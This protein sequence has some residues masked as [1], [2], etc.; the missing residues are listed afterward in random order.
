MAGSYCQR[1][2]RARPRTRPSIPSSTQLEA[3]VE[4]VGVEREPDQARERLPLGVRRE[5]ARRFG[6]ASASSP[7]IRDGGLG[8][9]RLDDLLGVGA[10]DRVDRVEALDVAEDVVVD[11]HDELEAL[12]RRQPGLGHHRERLLEVERAVRAV[13]DVLRHLDDPRVAHEDRAG[14]VRDLAH[15]GAPA[16]GQLVG[17][18]QQ[19]AHDRVL[20][21]REQLV[22]RADVVVERHRPGLRARRRRG[23]SRAPRSP[24][25][26]RCGSRRA[27]SRRACGRAVGR[28]ARAGSRCSRGRRQRGRAAGC[29]VCA[30]GHWTRRTVYC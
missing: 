19:L 15:P 6:N 24:R 1:R 10:R 14:A 29:G 7:A 25:R 11:E 2:G 3:A 13:V 18:D 17:R 20:D 30:P 12:V 16:G 8:R 9:E 23:A 27:R 21:E 26:R 28:A 5:S 4:P 22:L